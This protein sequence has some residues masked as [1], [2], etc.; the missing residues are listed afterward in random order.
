MRYQKLMVLQKNKS[1]NYW[2]TTVNHE[3]ARKKEVDV[4]KLQSTYR[5]Y[6][7]SGVKVISCQS[8]DLVLLYE[9]SQRSQSFIKTLLIQIFLGHSRRIF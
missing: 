8:W 7:M 9:S 5:G 2:F 3:K 1:Q 4:D 6:W